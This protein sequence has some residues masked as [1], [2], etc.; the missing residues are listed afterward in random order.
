M[1]SKYLKL[2]T[3]LRSRRPGFYQLFGARVLV[4]VLPDPEMKTAG[5][6]IIAS[7]TNQLTD[8]QENKFTAAIVLAVGKGYYDDEGKDVP[9]QVSVGQVVEVVRSGL[10]RYSTHPILGSE[11]VS[12][13]DLATVTE[14][15]ITGLLADNLGEYW[16]A[17]ESISELRGNS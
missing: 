5:G 9:L 6:L 4:E 7:K 17:I 1:T 12:K 16:A 15:Q 13:G 10:R 8:T 2:I 11:Y 14:N 3:A